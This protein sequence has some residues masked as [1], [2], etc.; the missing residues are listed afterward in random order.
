MTGMDP[1]EQPLGPA[2][3]GLAVAE[4][5]QPLFPLAA[6]QGQ[7]PSLAPHLLFKNKLHLP[8]NMTVQLEACQNSHFAECVLFWTSSLLQSRN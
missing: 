4:V 6:L 8:E 3:W 5:S 7:L 1:T 2:V